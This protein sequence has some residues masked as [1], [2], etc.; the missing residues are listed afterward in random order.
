MLDLSILFKQLT[1]G[2][3][4]ATMTLAISGPV[5]LEPAIQGAKSNL[6][7]GEPPPPAVDAQAIAHHVYE[8][9]RQEL[10]AMCDRRGE[11]TP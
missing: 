9:L 11:R 8:L 2:R 5:S 3:P 4:P 10:T 1:Q 6:E 7:A